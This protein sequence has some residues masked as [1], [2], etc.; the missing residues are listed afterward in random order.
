MMRTYRD[1]NGASDAVNFQRQ[2]YSWGHSGA[3]R[4]NS[5]SARA[6]LPK[7]SAGQSFSGDAP[8][9][10]QARAPVIIGE[11]YPCH[12]LTL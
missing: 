10:E 9:R 7:H 8:G 4:G 12:S 2:N 11:N 1:L 3:C 5:H 6:R